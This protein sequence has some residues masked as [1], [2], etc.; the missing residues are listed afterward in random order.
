MP[1]G[2]T[3]ASLELQD[4]SLQAEESRLGEDAAEEDFG[5]EPSSNVDESGANAAPASR[6]RRRRRGR[7][8]VMREDAYLGIER[9]ATEDLTQFDAGTAEPARETADA[10][11][12]DDEL[13]VG[14][15]ISSIEIAHPDEA[16]R[17]TED[18]E[19]PAK[20][21]RRRRRGRRS[22]ERPASAAPAH[23]ETF[24]EDDE[25]DGIDEDE[26]AVEGDERERVRP[27]KR[28]LAAAD[29]GGESGRE[30]DRSNKNLHREVTAWSEA[31]GYIISTN[32][33]ARARNPSAGQRG[34]WNRGDRRG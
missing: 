18:S 3:F 9:L 17:E 31:V 12:E 23:D 32:M 10:R 24:D 13:F 8:G 29:S 22:Q 26:D 25:D 7:R 34:R 11:E 16:D 30:G 14:E 21:R 1:R 19:L 27:G 33:E 15:E 5:D 28:R 4:S 20:R 2:E 6:R